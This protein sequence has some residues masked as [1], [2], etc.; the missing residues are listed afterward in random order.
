MHPWAR[1]ARIATLA[2]TAANRKDEIDG[3][4]VDEDDPDYQLPAERMQHY[5]FRSRP[6]KGARV[7]CISPEG[8]AS[9]RV[10]VASEAPGTGPGSQA[11]WE[12]EVYAKAGQ[13]LTYDKD[14]HATLQVATGKKI[15]IQAN[16]ATIEI[17][18]AGKITVTSAGGQDV[19]V[20]G[21]TLK[22]ARETDPVDAHASMATWIS[23]LTTYVNTIAP[24]TLVAP[25]GFGAIRSGAGAARFKG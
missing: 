24:G 20:N 18:A 11:E 21:G 14:G 16:G 9:Q 6:G 2:A 3:Y 10:S 15:T 7:V 8:G 5:G 17:S 19:Q 4:P 23:A 12:V 1:L 25:T 22:V 13:R